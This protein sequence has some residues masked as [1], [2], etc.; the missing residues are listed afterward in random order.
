MCGGGSSDGNGNGDGDG[1]G[2]RDD[3]VHGD[4]WLVRGSLSFDRC[5]LSDFRHDSSEVQR[6]PQKK[7]REEEK[8]K[9]IISKGN[10][11]L[12]C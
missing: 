7:K 6:T 8:K 12:S 11:M 9:Y 1:N 2:D 5:F 10:K 3:V 4:R